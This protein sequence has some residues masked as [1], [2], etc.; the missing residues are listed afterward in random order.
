MDVKSYVKLCEKNDCP[1]SDMT[2]WYQIAKSGRPYFTVYMCFIDVSKNFD[3]LR[4]RNWLKKEKYIY[5]T[6]FT[7]I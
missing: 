3:L 7:K 5:N 2:V 6:V 4:H 1:V